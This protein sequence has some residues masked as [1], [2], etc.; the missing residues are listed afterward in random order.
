[1]KEKPIPEK[2]EE[3]HIESRTTPSVD[4]TKSN[5]T[6]KR[7]MSSA[8]PLREFEHKD[9]VPIDYGE[10]Y[11]KRR[12][13]PNQKGMA[14]A[15]EADF[16]PEKRAEYSYDLETT[17][18]IFQK[19]FGDDE[20]DPKH[21]TEVKRTMGIKP[22]ASPYARLA[23]VYATG[24][25]EEEK[26]APHLSCE[27][28]E[29][30]C[31]VQEHNLDLSPTSTKLIMG[32]GRTI[33]P[34]GI[35]CNINVIISGKCIPT[36]FFV[37]DAYHSNH[38]HIIL[39]RPFL[40]LVDAVLDAGKGKVTINLNG[41]K[42]RYNFLRV[43][44]H[45][46]PFPPEDEEEE[47]VGSLCFVQT[48]RD[49]LQRAMENQSNDQQDEELEEATKGLEPQDGSVEKE[50]FEDIGDVKLKEPQVPEV[51]LKPFPKG[52]K[53]EFLGSYKTYPVIMS[54]ELSPEENEKLLNLLKKY[55]KVIGIQ[56]MISM[57]L[58]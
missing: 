22:E 40:K 45:P 8:K 43:S 2:L 25:E 13:F 58:A 21:I 32:D 27:N 57:D 3:V 51:D 56:L 38:D 47:E 36:N 37:I 35:A 7:S 42:Y 49:P 5:E 53:Y 41:K 31:K 29:V 12:S 17:S 48:L 44:K 9:W 30:Q 50:K 46:S 24:F 33:I 28:N 15:F 52:L 11:D 4:F 39:G 16:P 10:V 14:R 1:M 34:L 54:D 55:R 26:M 6:N 19:L 18:E 20:V 23:E